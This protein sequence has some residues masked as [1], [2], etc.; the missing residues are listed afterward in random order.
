METWKV[1]IIEDEKSDFEKIKADVVPQEMLSVFDEGD[2]T[3]GELSECEMYSVTKFKSTEAGALK[4]QIFSGPCFIS[5]SDLFNA[6]QYAAVILI[7]QLL[8]DLIQR[9]LPHSQLQNL[10][11]LFGKR[12]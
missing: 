7:S 4:A 10:L 11:I 3:T 9:V 12:L 1:L 8:C 2:N 6:F 5:Q